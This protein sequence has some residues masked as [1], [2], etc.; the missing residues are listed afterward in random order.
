MRLIDR[1]RRLIPRYWFM[2]DYAVRDLITLYGG[3][4]A[5]AYTF[6]RLA[7]HIAEVYAV[8]P[9]FAASVVRDADVYVRSL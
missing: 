5:N 3:G 6:E 1:I 2:Y 8:S 7:A 9:E 4:H